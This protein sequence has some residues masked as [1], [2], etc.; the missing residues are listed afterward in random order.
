MTCGAHE[1]TAPGFYDCSTIAHLES[2]PFAALLQVFSCIS[3]LKVEAELRLTGRL[4][5]T[6]SRHLGILHECIWSICDQVRV[7]YVQPI[8]FSKELLLI[9]L[10]ISCQLLDCGLPN[11]CGPFICAS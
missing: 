10:H 5:C 9:A 4:L 11:C 2:G 6:P 3:N 1:R 7:Q 8:C